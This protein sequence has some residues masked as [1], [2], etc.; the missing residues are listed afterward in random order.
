MTLDAFATVQTLPCRL[1]AEHGECS[2]IILKAV[3][4]SSGVEVTAELAPLDAF[5]LG[6]SI[7]DAVHGAST[8]SANWRVRP[9]ADCIEI[10]VL[11]RIVLSVPRG[12]A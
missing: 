11:G 5:L 1:S 2:Q 8:E 7:C 10:G 9:G 4:P 12:S 3:E 6:L